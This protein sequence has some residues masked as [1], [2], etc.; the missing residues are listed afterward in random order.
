[1]FTDR[2]AA[3]KMDAENKSWQRAESG[4][5]LSAKCIRPLLN[6]VTLSSQFLSSTSHHSSL[7]VV[8]SLF[9]WSCPLRNE[10]LTPGSLSSSNW[11][12]IVE[13]SVPQ[14]IVF[15]SYCFF[16][17][18][19]RHAEV[20]GPG[21]EPTPP[22]QPKPRQ[23]HQILTLPHHKETPEYTLSSHYKKKKYFPLFFYR[24]EVIDINLFFILAVISQYIKSSSYT[25]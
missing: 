25:L 6:A 10:A 17:P 14:D 24:Y 9:P 5:V 16:W 2:S 3:W 13:N 18:H 15:S 21:I 4:R 22:K 23:W 11:V 7:F 20:P 8:P 19:P 12:L 1:M